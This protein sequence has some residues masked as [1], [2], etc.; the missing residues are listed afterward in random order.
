MPEIITY[1]RQNYAYWKEY[2]E[3]GLTTLGDIKKLQ[4]TPQMSPI[5]R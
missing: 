2:D 4:Q 5:A 1:M 3:Q